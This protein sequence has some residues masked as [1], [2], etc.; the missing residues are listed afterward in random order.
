MN[1]MPYVGRDATGVLTREEVKY[2]ETRIIEAVHEHLI[3]RDLFPVVNLSDAGWKFYKYYKMEDMGQAVLSME[4]I[5][6]S[7]DFPIFPYSEV[8]VPII[9]KT[10]MLQW[11]DVLASRHQG[12]GL[13]AQVPRNAA[14]QIAEEE[15]KLLL[16]GEYTG[17]MAL[18]I[19]GLLRSA[20]TS[21][22]SLGAWPANAIADVNAARITLENAGFMN[23]EPILVGP[24]ALIKCLD[25]QL[26][27]TDTTYRK[28]LLDNGLVRAIYETRNLWPADGAAQDSVIL[29]IPGRDNYWMVQAQPPMVHWWDDKA[30]NHYGTVREAV[31]PVIAR[32]TSIVEIHTVECS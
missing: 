20:G 17:W 14:R 11:R 4:G 27:N 6:Q 3:G 1:N 16:T 28:F 29:T 22:L 23:T 26:T 21:S 13:L 15:D 19:L 9:S 8:K 30:G 10:C 32:P 31:A 24:P 2:I 18:G 5:A 12:E 7:D 25:R